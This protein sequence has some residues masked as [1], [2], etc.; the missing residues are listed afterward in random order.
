M[1]S[2]TETSNAGLCLRLALAA[3]LL[4]GLWAA[5][6]VA[7]DDSPPAGGATAEVLGEKL[8]TE[9]TGELVGS[10]LTPLLDR[11]AAQR[12]I[13]AGEAEIAAWLDRLERGKRD[14]GLT[15]EDDLTAEER[16]QLDRMQRDMAHAMIRQ[17]KINRALYRQYGG[18]I[19]FQQ[20]GPEPLDAY[21]EFLAKRHEAGD[22]RILRR[23]LEAPF[24]RYFSDDSIHS[25]YPAGSEEEAAAFTAPPWERPPE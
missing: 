18:R 1:P 5:S 6:V 23:S 9:N 15:A 16:E 2:V 12:G 17:W 24:W 4:I 10:V 13:D 3:G 7:G 11:Y 19:I 22:F 20:L 21:R 14:M 8:F 25:F